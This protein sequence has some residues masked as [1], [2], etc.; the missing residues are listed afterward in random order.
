MVGL[1]LYMQLTID[2]LTDGI[3]HP[4]NKL[5]EGAYRDVYSHGDYVV[6]VLKSHRRK[7]YGNN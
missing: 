4:S 1:L 3:F 6:K 7:N 5:K 2:N